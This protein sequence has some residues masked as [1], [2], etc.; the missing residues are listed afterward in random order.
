MVSTFISVVT[1]TIYFTLSPITDAQSELLARTSPTLYD[2]LIA[3]FWWCCWILSYVNKRKKQRGAGCCHCHSLNAT[4]LYSRLW[5]GR[6]KHILL[7]WG[8]LPLF[9]QYCFHCF[10]NLSWCTLS[11]FFIE[12]SLSIVKKMRRVN[13]Y[14]VSIIIITIIP[15][16]YY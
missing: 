13:L 14:I 10:Y 3:L 7:L 8:I 1:A 9:H 11:A 4:T 16:S 2:V 12:S 6:T 15:A 5:T